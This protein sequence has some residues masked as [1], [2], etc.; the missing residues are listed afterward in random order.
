MFFLE[1]LALAIIMYVIWIAFF[2]K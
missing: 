2:E 1:V